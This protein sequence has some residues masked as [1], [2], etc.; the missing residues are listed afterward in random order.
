[1]LSSSNNSEPTRM[2]LPLKE[3]RRLLTMLSMLN[4][5]ISSRKGKY[6][7]FKKTLAIIVAFTL[8]F[9]T[10]VNTPTTAFAKKKPKLN[11]SKIFLV[12]GKTYILK[13]K[14]NKKKVIW[15]TKNKKIATVS[16]KGKV[17]AKKAGTTKII[18]KVSNK[19]LVCKI[20][21]NKKTAV[22]KNKA[23]V[24]ASSPD[25]KNTTARITPKEYVKIAVP[26]LPSKYLYNND[27]FTVSDIRIEQSHSNAFNYNEVYVYFSGQKSSDSLGES[28]NFPIVINWKLYSLSG[29]VIESGFAMTPSI[30]VGD[31]FENVKSV[32]SLTLPNGS[33]R[34]GIE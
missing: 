16:S 14:N 12:I 23:N 26:I 17:K 20:T 10:T 8:V 9:S 34:L 22:S 24:S 5:S 4:L 11:K 28:H 19:K 18:A 27:E 31:K 1:M 15:Q 32:I 25:G 13:V 2:Y 7:K 21:V 30:S 6:M 33:Y 3:A 29:A